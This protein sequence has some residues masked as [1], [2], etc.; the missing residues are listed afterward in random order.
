MPI[1]TEST[2]QMGV[3]EN[4]KKDMKLV[5]S[6]I[7]KQV[8]RNLNQMS[9]VKESSSLYPVTCELKLARNTVF[10]EMCSVTA[11]INIRHLLHYHLPFFE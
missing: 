11:C 9:D 4:D 3:F 6:Y 10:L 1:Q 5:L 2:R 7:T 8:T